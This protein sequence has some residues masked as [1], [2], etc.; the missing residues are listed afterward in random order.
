MKRRTFARTAAAGAV[1]AAGLSA[2]SVVHAQ[3]KIRWRLASS[4]PKNLDT[5][6]FGAEQ[7]AR[8]VNAATNGAFEISV[9]APGELV[10]AF[11]VLDAVQQGSADCAHTASVFFFGKDPTFA[12]DTASCSSFGKD[13]TFALDD[14]SRAWY[15]SSGSTVKHCSSKHGSSATRS[16]DSRPSR[17][18]APGPA[19]TSTATA[20]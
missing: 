11:G 7:V 6:Y 16:T 19:T 18:A 12:L 20:R 13:P 3:P 5:I 2:S 4:W 9:F 15:S 14:Q 17:A 1:G 10:P 8:R